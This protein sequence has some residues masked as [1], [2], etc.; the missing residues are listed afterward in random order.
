MLSNE[1][2]LENLISKALIALFKKRFDTAEV[3]ILRL[4]LSFEE[5]SRVAFA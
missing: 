2:D 5:E 4:S 3:R 1:G